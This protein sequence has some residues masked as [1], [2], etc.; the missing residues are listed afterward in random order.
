MDYNKEILQKTLKYLMFI[1]LKIINQYTYKW[2][3]IK[4]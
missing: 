2:N 4:N 3:I 1:L